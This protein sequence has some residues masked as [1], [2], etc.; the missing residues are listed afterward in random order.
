M[1]PSVEPDIP[2]QFFAA[3]PDLSILGLDRDP[4]ARRRRYR[5][6]VGLRRPGQGRSCPLRRLHSGP[7]RTVGTDRIGPFASAVLFDLGVSSVQFDRPERG[8]SYRVDGPLDMRM[9]T[10]SGQ[11]AADV[12]NTYSE[13]ALTRLMK[14]YAD[15]RFANRNRPGHQLPPGR[16]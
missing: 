3:M 11:T 6:V 13:A 1:P 5:P 8:F 15:E 16:F 9:D 10:T 4:V 2:A 7:G 14:V 12:V